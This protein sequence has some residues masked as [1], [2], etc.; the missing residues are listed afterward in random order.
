M[1]QQM[2]QRDG[3]SYNAGVRCAMYRWKIRTV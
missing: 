3:N 1:N 2:S